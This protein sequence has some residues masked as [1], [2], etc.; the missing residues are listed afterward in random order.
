[1][2]GDIIDPNDPASL[3]FNTSLNPTQE[4]EVILVA[5]ATTVPEPITLSIFGAG[6][7]GVVAIRRRKKTKQV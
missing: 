5:E 2:L 4:G 3:A 1:M 7:A 6:L